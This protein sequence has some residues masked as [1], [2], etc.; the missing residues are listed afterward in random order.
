MSYL[1]NN[2]LLFYA[3]GPRRATRGHCT[4]PTSSFALLCRAGLHEIAPHGS[5][6]L[7]HSFQPL[8]VHV[9]N[10]SATKYYNVP[11]CYYIYTFKLL[12]FFINGGRVC[13]IAIMA[14]MSIQNSAICNKHD[15]QM[16]DY[17]I[18][19]ANIVITRSLGSNNANPV[20]SESCHTGL[21]RSYNDQTLS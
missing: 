20:V 9:T 17:I 4:S 6:K 3:Y 1:K 15:C 8:Y 14:Y 13:T 21:N 5:A 18:I 10:T 19:Q 7:H 2:R 11:L 16:D 12:L